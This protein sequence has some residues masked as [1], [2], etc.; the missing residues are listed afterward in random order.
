MLSQSAGCI[1]SLF[2]F[3]VCQ[4]WLP[5]EAIE[6]WDTHDQNTC[7]TWGYTRCTFP[8][9]PLLCVEPRDRNIHRDVSPWLL[10]SLPTR[11]CRGLI[12][13][14]QYLSPEPTLSIRSFIDLVCTHWLLRPFLD[15]LRKV[16]ILKVQLKSYIE[17][18]PEKD[19]HITLS[20]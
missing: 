17:N 10:L 9:L 6:I 19:R 3:L 11:L 14:C 18:D 1:S 8:G 15:H 7:L 2:H 16:P 12:C 13:S 5:Q 4:L 20:I